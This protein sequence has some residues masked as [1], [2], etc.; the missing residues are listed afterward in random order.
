MLRSLY[1]HLHLL[2]FLSQSPICR[3]PFLNC[4]YPLRIFAGTTFSIFGLNPSLLHGEM[5]AFGSSQKFICGS[6]SNP[7][8]AGAKYS[9]KIQF[10]SSLI[11]SGPGRSFGCFLK[12]V[13][14]KSCFL[15]SMIWSHRVQVRFWDLSQG[16]SELDS[17]FQRNYIDSIFLTQLN[18]KIKSK[19]M[20]AAVTVVM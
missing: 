1:N 5:Y 13:I 10:W 2:R 11:I 6:F 20:S 9:L 4:Q 14:L 3:F 19:L 15:S 16:K 17:M 7:Q 8:F 12:E 18:R